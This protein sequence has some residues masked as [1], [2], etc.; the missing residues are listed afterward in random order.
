MRPD[1]SDVRRL[2]HQRAYTPA[3]SP[4]GGHIVFAA[5]GLFVMNPDGTRVTPL[6]TENAGETSLADWIE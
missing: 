1:G 5:P 2:T 6:P 4:D 3:W